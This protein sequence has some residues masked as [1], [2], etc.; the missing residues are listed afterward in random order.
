MAQLLWVALLLSLAPPAAGRVRSW[1]PRGHVRHPQP[2]AHAGKSYAIAQN[3]T[4]PDS[5]THSR[6]GATAEW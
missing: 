5:S 2:G 4:G 1:G 6:R 3:E